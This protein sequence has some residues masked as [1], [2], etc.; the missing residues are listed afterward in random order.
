MMNPDFIQKGTSN[1]YSTEKNGR[2]IA[3]N[4]I[5]L[6]AS[7]FVLPFFALNW[8]FGK[9]EL[10]IVNICSTLLTVITL[11]LNRKGKNDEALFLFFHISVFTL[12]VY[13][14]LLGPE[15]HLEYLTGL[16]P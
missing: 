10:I 2:I 11:F 5:A 1:A 14:Y 7:V 13:H 9:S 6:T 12:L 8:Y 4:K 15:A 16:I 3:Y